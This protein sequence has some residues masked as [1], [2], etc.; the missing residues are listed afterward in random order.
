[1]ADT[2]LRRDVVTAASVML[3]A[4]PV[5]PDRMRV[6]EAVV[7]AA[8]IMRYGGETD[9]VAEEVLELCATRMGPGVSLV[10]RSD[11]HDDEWVTKDDTIQWDFTDSYFEYLMRNSWAPTIVSQL[12]DVTKNI[13]GHVGNPKDGGSW[14]RQ[15]LVMGHV[16][17]G[18]TSNYIGLI[19]RAADAGYG[20]IIVI[21]G[22]HNNL[23]R[24]TQQ[25]VDEG[26]IGRTSGKNRQIIGAGNLRPRARNVISLTSESSDFRKETASN[27]YLTLGSS[28]PPLV[29][30]IKKNV[31]TL[32]TLHD[33]LHTLN[34]DAAQRI[35]GVPLI[36][37]D[38][39]ADNA[40]INTKNSETDPTQTNLWIRKILRLFTRSSY[41]G[42]TATP[43]ANILINPD[44]QHP[45]VEED[46]FP[47]DFIYSL[48]PPSTYFGPNAVFADESGN[49]T[50]VIDDA[51][52][53]LPMKHAKDA[54]ID[55]LPMSLTRAIDQFFCAKAI[56]IL[57]GQK[58]RHNSMMINVSRFVNVQVQIRNLVS[59]YVERLRKSVLAN[60]ALAENY[61]SSDSRFA[62]LHTEFLRSYSNCG[63][64]WSSV[65]T[66]LGKAFGNLKVVVINSRSDETLDYEAYSRSGDGLTAIAIGGLSLSRGLTLEGLTISYMYRN[67]RMYD[68]LMQ[69]G[70]WFGYRPGYEDLCRVHLPA[71]SIAWY[72]HIAEAIEGVRD[73]IR[74]MRQNNLSPKK[75]GMYILADPVANEIRARL[76][77]TA[78]NKMRHGH[79]IKQKQNFSLS[80]VE[81]WALSNDRKN[82]QS[83]EEL[84]RSYWENGFGGLA[85][86]RELTELDG[87]PKGWIEADAPTMKIRGFVDA[88]RVHESMAFKQH[89]VS[90]FLARICE[91]YPTCDVVYISIKENSS[92]NGFALGY[93][94]R[95]CED[96]PTPQKDY[97]KLSRSRVASRGD[98]RL[99]LDLKK[100][101]AAEAAAG[102]SASGKKL[103][104]DRFYRKERSKPLLMIH[105]LSV[106]S[107]DQRPEEATKIFTY[108]ISF[109]DTGVEFATEVDIVANQ[110]YL[111]EMFGVEGDDDSIDEEDYE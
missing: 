54:E 33:W 29:V 105:L 26:F 70:R 71:D 86:R 106:R 79:A 61:A 2:D 110:L 52:D 76:S 31:S 83:N 108:G 18:K 41:V 88:F 10:E 90:D 87:G 46:L 58:D 40:S 89:S 99:G 75:F 7:S 102:T 82:I 11:D 95:T 111:D 38:D 103:V 81:I 9:S 23:R 109:P 91:K 35:T 19:S 62:D 60:Y 104:S 96:R 15:G 36:M 101:K 21:A 93:Q 72:E 69:M 64:E 66:A 20:F 32:R 3:G 92:Y 78:R 30:V 49:A 22:I 77:V 17:S 57:R 45:E 25:R 59:D 74:I 37:V 48:D 42:Y 27:V 4:D 12:R 8:A 85:P 53:I 5:I 28:L 51:E 100:R 16:Q 50:Q 55:A 43:F 39:E 44:A 84:V 94:E 13:L 80:L 65:R 63:F 24:Q 68:T 6:E 97:W 73:Q 1:M 34:A 67:T 47:R 98:E 56:R 107:K 14:R